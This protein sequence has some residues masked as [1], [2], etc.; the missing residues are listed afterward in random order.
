MNVLIAE[1]TPIDIVSSE[2]VSPEYGFIP[3]T[4]MWW[5]HTRNPRKPIAHSASAIARYPN[6]GLREKFASTCETTPIPGRIAMYTSGC[7]KNQN[8]CCHSSGEPPPC[9][10]SSPL[11]TSPPGMKKLVPA[12]R[13][14]SSRIPPANN[15]LN[16][17]RLR[18]A[19][20]NHAHTV[21]GMRISVIP[22]ARMSI[23]VAMNIQRTEQRSNAENQNADDP[24]RLAQPLARAR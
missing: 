22:G 16:A 21:S 6:T 2:N 14:S 5:P 11:T 8:R 24:Q 4:N 9:P 12:E 19:V 13:S 7:P 23:V 17:S 18:I 10:C 20:T 1:G 3:L 15:T